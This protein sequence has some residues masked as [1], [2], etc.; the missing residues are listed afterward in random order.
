M[1][2]VLFEILVLCIVDQNFS[3]VFLK[4][5][6]FVHGLFIDLSIVF[7]L[8][9]YPINLIDNFLELDGARAVFINQE[10]EL[11]EGI[12]ILVVHQKTGDKLKE[13]EF[14]RSH[15]CF[16]MVFEEEHSSFTK[17]FKGL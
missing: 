3:E 14:L 12:S 13:S 10:E 15:F 16:R 1:D 4:L 8:T 11:S 6:K 7:I 2:V 17:I 5:S 9:D